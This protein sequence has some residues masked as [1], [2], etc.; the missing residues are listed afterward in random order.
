MQRNGLLMLADGTAF[1]GQSVGADGAFVGELIFNTAMTGYQEILTDPSYAQQIIS[2]TYPHIGNVGVNSEDWESTRIWAG[3]VIM[4]QLS[5]NYCN[6]RAQ[7]DL[8]SMLKEQQV[9]AISGID[10]RKLTHIIRKQGS[11][12]ACAMGGA[13]INT[14]TALKQAQEF[15][16]LCG[17]DLAAATSG[18]ASKAIALCQQ[19]SAAFHVVVMDFGIKNAILQQLI[20]AGCRLTI[21]SAQTSAAEI[22]KLNP[23]GV[24]LSNG[25]GDPAAC[26]YAIEAIRC[27]LQ[28]EVPLFGICLGHQL[29]ALACG[30]TTVKMDSGH[31]G[32][33]HPIQELATGK[34]FIS[35]QNHGFMVAEH[36]LP[37]CLTITHRSLFDQSIAGIRHKDKPAFSF[38]GHPEAS[39]GPIELRVLFQHFID[40]M[41]GYHA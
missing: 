8:Q 37:T 38:Q 18:Y 28:K 13:A 26:Q 39:P 19:P 17:K 30:G 23:Q 15:A 31:H 25:P 27:L 9:I 36:D 35:T 12:S 21:V 11:I 14:D 22:L 40:L 16:G 5:Q 10:T 3:A 24:F 29:L 4:R 41:E 2:F 20:A 32:S 34:V 33:N 7:G 6:W 1:W